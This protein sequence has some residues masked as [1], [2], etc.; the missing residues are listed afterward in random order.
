[1]KPDHY[2][3]RSLEQLFNDRIAA[4]RSNMHRVMMNVLAS[5]DLMMRSQV[6]ANQSKKLRKKRNG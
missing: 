1:M 4:H 5:R 2:I 6:L 3:G